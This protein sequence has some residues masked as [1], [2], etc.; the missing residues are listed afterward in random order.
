MNFGNPKHA[1]KS[2]VMAEDKTEYKLYHLFDSG[3]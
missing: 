2:K 3:A 1:V